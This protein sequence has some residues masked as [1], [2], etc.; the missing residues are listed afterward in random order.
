VL[1]PEVRARVGCVRDPQPRQRQILS[2]G[3]AD[4]RRQSNHGR[5]R[6]NFRPGGVDGVIRIMAT[7]T[8]PT[9]SA[10]T[11]GNANMTMIGGIVIVM[12]CPLLRVVLF[13]LSP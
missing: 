1:Q 5:I 6:G 3:V 9:A 4:G 13:V 8:A 10:I 7:R 11:A 12:I 2:S